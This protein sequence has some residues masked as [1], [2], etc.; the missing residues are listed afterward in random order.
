MNVVWYCGHRD[1][2]SPKSDNVE[3]SR[4]LRDMREVDF[5]LERDSSMIVEI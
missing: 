5:K 1:R 3:S 2:P 4:P